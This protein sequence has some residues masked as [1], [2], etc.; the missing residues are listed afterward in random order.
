VKAPRS[1]IGEVMAVAVSA[2]GANSLF[3]EC[4]RPAPER[5]AVPEPA[6]LET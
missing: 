3:G 5:I 1:L 6:S 4:K 2:T